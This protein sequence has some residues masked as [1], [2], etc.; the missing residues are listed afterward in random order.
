MNHLEYYILKLYEYKKQN[1]DIKIGLNRFS[2]R[3]RILVMVLL[4]AMLLSAILMAILLIRSP[5]N[6]M[7]LWGLI[8]CII[9]MITL[10][11]IDESESK[12]HIGQYVQEYNKRINLLHE[13]LVNDFSIDSKEKLSAVITMF[14]K[15]LEEQA[16]QEKKAEKIA[17]TVITSLSGIITTTLANL[18]SIGMEFKEWLNIAALI[19]VA[20]AMTSII[21]YIVFY[22]IRNLN[23]KKDRYEAVVNDLQYIQLCKYQ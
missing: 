23:A 20:V 4:A 15:Y 9:L 11:V 19:L 22:C 3:K 6:L 14:K 12:L 7:C 2:S 10:L 16:K 17:V 1:S 13:M 5:D 21:I 18:D 8:P